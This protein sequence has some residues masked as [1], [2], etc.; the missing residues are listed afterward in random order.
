MR[1]KRLV[2]ASVLCV[3]SPF[4]FS[5]S[6]LTDE[7]LSLPSVKS[8]VFFVTDPHNVAKHQIATIVYHNALSIDDLDVL[9]NYDISRDVIHGL[10]LKKLVDA[11]PTDQQEDFKALF[12]SMNEAGESLKM[13]QRRRILTYFGFTFFMLLISF[14][15]LRKDSHEIHN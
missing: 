12:N 3:V 9:E 4:S 10:K 5:A 1:F 14:I 13:E 15:T 8:E 11:L 7:L 2:L 6:L